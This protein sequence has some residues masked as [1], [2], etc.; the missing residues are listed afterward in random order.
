MIVKVVA[1]QV[2]KTG[3]IDFDA[4]DAVLRQSVAGHF[5]RDVLI[6]F[7]FKLA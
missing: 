1:G 4:A 6:T 7:V 2:G 5:H 3:N